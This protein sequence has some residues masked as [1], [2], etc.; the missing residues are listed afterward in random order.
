MY[1]ST[2]FRRVLLEWQFKDDLGPL[3]RRSGIC[4]VITDN[5]QRS[6][7]RRSVNTNWRHLDQRA[8]IHKG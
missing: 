5:V 8:A 6:N 7:L 3:L 4:G 1:I 2:R